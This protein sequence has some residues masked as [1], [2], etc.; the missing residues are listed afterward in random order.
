M[1]MDRLLTIGYT[2][3]SLQKFIELLREADVDAVID[4]RRNNTSQLAGFAKR[5]DLAYLLQTGFGIRYEHRLELAPT[6]EIRTRYRQ[7]RDWP[8]YVEAFERLMEETAMVAAARE[9]LAPYRRP[10][11]LCAEESPERCHR[12][13]LAERLQGLIPGLEVVHL[14]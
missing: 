9:A 7:D 5:D 2:R 13:L 10:C 1:G 12:R 14:R 11:L 6:E 4:T 3:K 8:A